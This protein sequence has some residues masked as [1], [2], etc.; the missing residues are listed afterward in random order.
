MLSVCSPQTSGGLVKSACWSPADGWYRSMVT[1]GPLS[2]ATWAIP[3]AGP[4]APS[5]AIRVPINV[6]SSPAP[7]ADDEIARLPL[8]P[9][10]VCELHGPVRTMLGRSS[11][12][13]VLFVRAV[14]VTPPSSDRCKP[15]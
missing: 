5:H 11:S 14:Q 2:T 8:A 4:L 6:Y 12:T 15:S 10:I 13:R 3:Y 9:G 7:P 1:G